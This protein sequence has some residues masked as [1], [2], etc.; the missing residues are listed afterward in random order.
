MRFEV[1]GL[2]KLLVAAVEGADVG[3]ISSVD[4]DVSSEVEVEREPFA[5]ALKGALER[6]LAGVDQLKREIQLN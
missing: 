5:A 1:R 3:A 2:R 4:S 6:L